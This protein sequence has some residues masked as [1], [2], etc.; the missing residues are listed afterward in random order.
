MTS[1]LV[2]G[3]QRD[4]KKINGFIINLSINEWQGLPCKNTVFRNAEKLLREIMIRIIEAVALQ[5]TSLVTLISQV[6]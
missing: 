3:T 1:Y 5:L 4:H 6:S 2:I